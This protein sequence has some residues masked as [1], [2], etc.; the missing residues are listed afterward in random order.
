MKNYYERNR[1][2]QPTIP[3]YCSAS[4]ADLLLKLLKRNAKDRI[5]FS[6]THKLLLSLHSTTLDDF[7][8]H[9][10]LH[11]AAVASPSKRI[12][13]QQRLSPNHIRRVPSAD[14]HQEIAHSPQVLHRVGSEQSYQINTN[15]ATN[16]RQSTVTRALPAT[17]T[18]SPIRRSSGNNPTTPRQSSQNTP[19]GIVPDRHEYIYGTSSNKQQHQSPLRPQKS[20]PNPHNQMTDS[21]E[22]TFLPPLNQIPSGSNTPR[23]ARQ[24]SL[25]ENAVKQVQVHSS[26]TSATN[27]A[28]NNTRAVPVPSQR[29]AFAKMEQERQNA[30]AKDRPT[31]S[32]EPA[33]NELNFEDMRTNI[34][35]LNP[36]QSK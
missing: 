28:R 3:N 24:T 18:S 4:L 12:L 19:S 27:L 7:F 34:E 29:L 31:S 11:Q 35:E 9:K 33:Q 8:N 21:G 32:Q 1:D 5:D 36:P 22:F 17:Y 15:L 16:I 25:N 23:S 2:L 13:E 20:T 14:H 30:N 10:F 6:K 26:K